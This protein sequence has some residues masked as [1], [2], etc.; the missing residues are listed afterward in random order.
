M[1]GKERTSLAPLL[2]LDFCRAVCSSLV[3]F[4]RGPNFNLAT[5]FCDI[6]DSNLSTVSRI[7]EFEILRSTLDSPEYFIISTHGGPSGLAWDSLHEAKN[8]HGRHI[9]WSLLE[10]MNVVNKA[11]EI[12]E[13]KRKKLPKA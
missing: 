8:K 11:L 13:E 1:V 12:L 6:M 3:S 5:N 2:F 9:F 7:K 10:A 4:F